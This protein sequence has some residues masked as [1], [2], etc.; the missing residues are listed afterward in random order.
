M[1]RLKRSAVL[2]ALFASG[3]A[4]GWPRPP[5]PERAREMVSAQ[6][7]PPRVD[8]IIVHGCPVRPDG[9]PSTCNERR[10]RAA[11]EAWR[12]GYA[13]RVLF[14]G[15]PTANP[16]AEAV[17]MAG[18]AR[19]LG[20]PEAAILVETESRHTATNLW[21]ARRLMRTEGLATAL[22]VSEAMH[23]VWAKQLALFLGMR[24][25]LYP[26]DPLPPYPA[27][28]QRLAR[29][30]AWEPWQTQTRAYGAPCAD[31]HRALG[32]A[33]RRV[34]L[35]AL[36]DPAGRTADAALAPALARTATVERQV[37]PL[38]R[39]ASPARN[40]RRLALWID[41]W[42]QG[43]NGPCDEVVVVVPE[44]ALRVARAAA[45]LRRAPGD[46][47]VRFVLGSSGQAI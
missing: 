21:V 2:L 11:V 42:T 39:F 44:A 26:A 14:T 34:A 35:L 38:S 29:F 28:Y 4:A 1:N 32:R 37:V 45:A 20:L 41:G 19:R 7:I 16:H 6:T 40:A 17:V 15:G 31:E 18:V 36:A 46:V 10:A 47:A 12:R 43:Y 13:P 30:D 8:L 23:L 5:T 9:L 25:W 3:C 22:Q 27:A 33:E 24:T